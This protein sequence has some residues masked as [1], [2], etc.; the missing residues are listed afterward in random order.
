MLKVQWVEWPHYLNLCS[1]NLSSFCVASPFPATDVVTRTRV[2]IW[3]RGSNRWNVCEAMM[4]TCSRTELVASTLGQSCA[5]QVAYGQL[6]ILSSRGSK[7][8]VAMGG[9]LKDLMIIVS[10]VLNLYVVYHKYLLFCLLFGKSWLFC[11]STPFYVHR[12][13]L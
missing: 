2:E 11:L 5:P 13:M 9:Q 1:I 7:M 8:R 10:H 3:A 12:H 6:W 4:H